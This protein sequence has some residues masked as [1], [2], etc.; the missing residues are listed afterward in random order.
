MAASQVRLDDC[1]AVA[2][3]GM[4]AI[5][6]PL[7]SLLEDGTLAACCTATRTIDGVVAQ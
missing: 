3:I 7:R 5:T 6:G 4:F 1:E 2:G